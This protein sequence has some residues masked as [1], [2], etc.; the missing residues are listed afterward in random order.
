MTGRRPV[1]QLETFQ[2]VPPFRMTSL[3]RIA[4]LVGAMHYVLAV[5]IPGDSVECGST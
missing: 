4:A 2:P 1:S 3:E 5:K